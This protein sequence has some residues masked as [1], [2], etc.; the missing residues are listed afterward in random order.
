MMSHACGTGEEVPEELVRLM[1][2]LKAQSLSYGHSG[3]QVATVQ[4]LL[5]LYNREMLPVVYQQGSL[6]RQ[7]RSGAAGAL[8]LAAAG[9]GRSELSGLPPWRGR[10]HELV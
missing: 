6:G 5:D 10:C 7:R 1:L 8:V 9:P 4:R 2:L 3:V